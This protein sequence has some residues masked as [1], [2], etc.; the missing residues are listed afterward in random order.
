MDMSLRTCIDPNCYGYARYAENY[1]DKPIYCSKHKPDDYVNVKSV[2]CLHKGC[3]KVRNFGKPGTKK[4]LYCGEH[5]KA[6]HV[7]IG[8]I[9]C[10]YKDCDT[11]AS[12]GKEGE[13]AIYCK[14]HSDPNLHVDV[15]NN[16]CE[17][18][19]CKKQAIYGYPG[20]VTVRCKSHRLKDM[21]STP[22]SN[23]SNVCSICCATA[24]KST[25]TICQG[26]Q[27]FQK[28]KITKKRHL[29]EL[30]IKHRLEDARIK[31][32]HDKIVERGCS[33]KRP[34]FQIVTIW[35]MI[36][37]EVDEFQHS[38]SYPCDCE[39]AR[40]KIIYMDLG[41]E[42]VLFIRYNPDNYKVIKGKPFGREGRERYLIRYLKR[43]MIKTPEYNLGAVY[44]FYDGFQ[45]KIPDIET[46]DPYKSNQY[47]NILKKIPTIIHDIHVYKF[48]GICMFIKCLKCGETDVYETE[49]FLQAID[50]FSCPFC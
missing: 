12:F 3:N 48:T 40:M 11:I 2:K 32:I 17:K 24:I 27:D 31:F 34:D 35:G 6:H 43:A 25:E 42:K 5:K 50:E 18:K 46:F 4:T 16:T 9:I 30:A 14:E 19:N 13:S 8:K 49:N 29:K 39:L 41:V 26:C 36:I 28:T 45:P 47:E 22:K 10:E 7:P 44:L 33:K 21:I 20:G 15:H 1:G 38:R 23:R 37:L